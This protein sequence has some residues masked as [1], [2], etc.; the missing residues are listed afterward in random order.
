[1]SLT[2]ATFVSSIAN[3]MPVAASDPGFQ[4]VLPNII[5][6]T[7]QRLYRE[8]NLL[9]TNTRDN[10]SAFT[11]G[12]RTFTIPTPAAGP[13]I[14]V[15]EIN[16]ITPAGTT[17]PESGTRH[18]L[19]PVSNELLNE[20]YPSVAGSTV[21]QYFS[22]LDPNRIIVGPWP[23]AAYQ[24]EIVGEIRPNAL[25]V[26]NVTTVLSTYFPD[27]MLAAGMVFAAGY[28]K[29]FGAM[30]D[31][32]KMAITWETHLQTLLKSVTLE[33]ARKVFFGEGW[34]SEQPSPIAT[35]PRT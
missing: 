26:S 33:E 21:P 28:Q 27:L 10:S 23:N 25:S 9:W 19:L 31:D 18:S 3:M 16:A 8:L 24:V 15:S 7:E 14:V 5:D 17:N 29:N 12:A 13:F 22:M 32:P 6:D 4:A 20:L 30:V 1:M 2:Y 11:A 35:P 34:S